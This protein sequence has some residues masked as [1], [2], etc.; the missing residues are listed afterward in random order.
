MTEGSVGF[1]N[2]KCDIMDLYTKKVRRFMC[3]P[4]S[5]V[6]RCRKKRVFLWHRTVSVTML[7]AD[8]DYRPFCTSIINQHVDSS[9]PKVSGNSTPHHPAFCDPP[10]V[11]LSSDM[12]FCVYTCYAVN[13]LYVSYTFMSNMNIYRVYSECCL[14]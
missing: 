3:K 7:M 6:E 12:I 10:M 5:E 11:H 1:M 4:G 14:L 13:H 8:L 9:L 2:E